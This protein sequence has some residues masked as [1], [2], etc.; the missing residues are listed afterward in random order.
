MPPSISK[1]HLPARN[2]SATYQCGRDAL[3]AVK[4]PLG[5]WNWVVF[6]ANPE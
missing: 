5:K 2:V 3:Q 4:Q 1:P 6:G